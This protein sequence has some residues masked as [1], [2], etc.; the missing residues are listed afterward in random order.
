MS[1]ISIH[2]GYDLTLTCFW[3]LHVGC[4]AS[5]NT[6]CATSRCMDV[7]DLVSCVTYAPHTAGRLAAAVQGRVVATKLKHLWQQRDGCSWT[8]R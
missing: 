7:Y 1:N 3:L 2:L 6:V 4:S 5:L 8:R